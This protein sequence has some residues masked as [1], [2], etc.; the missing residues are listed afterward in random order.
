MERNV[1]TL[2]PRLE[3]RLCSRL[4]SLV[5]AK[6]SQRLLPRWFPLSVYSLRNYETISGGGREICS[7]KSFI[8]V[9]RRKGRER[10]I[11]RE[12]K[13]EREG[14]FSCLTLTYRKAVSHP[15]TSVP[16]GR[17]TCVVIGAAFG[18]AETPNRHVR[19]CTRTARA[20]VRVWLLVNGYFRWTTVVDGCN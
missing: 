17:Y 10:M 3:R 5:Q 13:T 15:D 18:R 14:A 20:V 1:E 2:S 19:T 6:V 7:Y 8:T 9:E 11:E 4:S 16:I 12:R